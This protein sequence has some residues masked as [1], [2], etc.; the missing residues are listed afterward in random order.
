MSDLECIWINDD[1]LSQIKT[2]DNIFLYNLSDPYSLYPYLNTGHHQKDSRSIFYHLSQLETSCD[3]TYIGCDIHLKTNYERIKEFLNLNLNIVCF[4]WFFLYDYFTFYKIESCKLKSETIPLKYNAIFLSGTKR[5]AR[6]HIISE[7]SVYDTFRYSNFEGIYG[8]LN[9]DEKKPKVFKEILDYSIL[10]TD[11]VVS[12]YDYE[13][14][15]Q[16]EKHLSGDDVMDQYLFNFKKF[17]SSIPKYFNVNLDRYINPF[18]KITHPYLNNIVPDEYLQSAVNFACESQTD[19]STHITEKT[20]KNFFYKKPFLTF[21]CKGFYQFLT[22]NGFLLY[23]EL[24][25]Y[26]FDDIDN[27]GQRLTR[28]LTECEKIL[29]MELTQLESIIKNFQYKLDYNYNICCEI[30]NTDTFKKYIK[31]YHVIYD[32]RNS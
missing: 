24:F 8:N 30:V 17:N 25:D 32:S 26:T 15:D 1:I 16:E 6:Y 13:I 4:P 2:S 3:I 18:K 20:T 27:Y 7:L 10:D 21:A 11:F 22:N 9:I 19:I 31:K 12:Y 5:L 28:Y 23:D 14:R 29:Q